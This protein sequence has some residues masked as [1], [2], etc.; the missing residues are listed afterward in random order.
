LLNSNFMAAT[1]IARHHH[2]HH[3]LTRRVVF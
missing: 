2:R 3:A 1:P